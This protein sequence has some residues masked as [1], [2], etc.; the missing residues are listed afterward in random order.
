MNQNN[1]AGSQSLVRQLFFKSTLVLLLLVAIATGAWYVVT[2]QEKAIQ[3]VESQKLKDLNGLISQVNFLRSQVKL[4]QLYGDKYKDLVRKGIVKKQDRVFW[5]DSMIQMQ[6]SLV[7]PKFTFKFSPEA[8]L[9]SGSFDRLKIDKSI[10]YY[11][12]LNIKMALQHEGDLLTFLEA[13]NE[14]VSPLYLVESCRTEM[15]EGELEDR[16]ALSFDI[17]KGNVTVDCSFVVF[18]SHAKLAI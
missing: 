15:I 12:L 1:T 9:S 14:R 7:M 3:K 8:V 4:Y 16:Q 17:D 2:E 5:V 11:S 18:H 10:F 6:Q 13:M